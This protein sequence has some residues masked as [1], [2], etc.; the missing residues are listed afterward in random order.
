[1]DV[2]QLS[3]GFTSS[4][5]PVD[6]SA[7]QHTALVY[8]RQC[9]IDAGN[10]ERRYELLLGNYLAF[11]EFCAVAHLRSQIRMDWSYETGDGLI[12]EANR[13]VI[14]VL[15]SG[16]SYVDQVCRDFKG[17]GAHLD[18]AAQ[19]TT[20]LGRAFDE[21][22]D[23]RLAYQLRDRAQHRAMPVDGFDGGPSTREHE[24]VWF[25]CSKAKIE[26][27]PGKFKPRI[28]KQAPDK[29]YL[30]PLL[31]GYV[32]Q[33]SRVHVALRELVSGEIL[34]SRTLLTTS[35]Q[36]YAEAQPPQAQAVHTG[37]G[38]ESWHVRDGVVLER[39]PLL[40]NW[41]DNRKRLAEKNRF[42]I[43]LPE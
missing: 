25:Y 27:D 13:H 24:D 18:F 30:R 21:S 17:L 35:I 37:I 14:N 22:L 31:G 32:A 29:M 23:Y 39:V 5:H 43:R 26:A 36:A 6:I 7:E 42:A 16:K 41:D 8:A 1:M 2:Y 10:F 33:L 11:E 40:L 12:M 34:T 4:V 3:G 19:A 9:L 28:L 20:L 15:A 38:I